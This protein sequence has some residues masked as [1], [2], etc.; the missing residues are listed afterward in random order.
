MKTSAS[1]LPAS[2]SPQSIAGPQRTRQQRFPLKLIIRSI[3][4][5]GGVHVRRLDTSATVPARNQRQEPSLVQPVVFPSAG[6][7]WW[8]L[9]IQRLSVGHMGIYAAGS[10]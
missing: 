5:T 6:D 8:G 1:G 2:L 4:S 3:R 9:F 10:G 7:I